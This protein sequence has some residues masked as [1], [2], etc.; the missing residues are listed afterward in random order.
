MT[1]LP[2]YLADLHRK[3]LAS[4]VQVVEQI[5]ATIHQLEHLKAVHL[6]SLSRIA[7][8]IA[9]DEGHADHGEH[10]H[11]AVEAEVAVA[12]RM[13]Q[14]VVA[15]QMGH[16]DALLGDYPEL[17]RVFSEG[18]V[19]LRHTEVVVDAGQIVADEAARAAYEAAVLPLALAM[20]PAQLRAHARRLAELHAERSIDERHSEARRRRG[21]RVVDL[22]DGMAQLIATLGAAD[23]YAIRD[24]LSRIAH[25]ARKGKGTRLGEPP[26]APPARRRRTCSWIC[27]C[28]AAARRVA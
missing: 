4:G 21:V 17:G 13:P 3:A 12:T 5:E 11:R 24:R 22:D 8:R 6:A 16:A 2:P 9:R 25:R 19:S 10:V 20:T 27:C 26:S 7:T 18:R 28:R 15:S 23:A 14:S 1:H